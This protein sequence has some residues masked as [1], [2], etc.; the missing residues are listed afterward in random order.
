MIKL[1][2]QMEKIPC[3]RCGKLHNN[4]LCRMKVNWNTDLKKI[5]II[6]LNNIFK[7]A[8]CLYSFCELINATK[9]H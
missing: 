5:N 4:E 1:N 7:L 2:I 3:Y 9:R 8:L 6:F